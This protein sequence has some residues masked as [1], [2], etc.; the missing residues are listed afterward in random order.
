MQEDRNIQNVTLPAESHHLEAA[1]LERY[2]NSMMKDR[3]ED[4]D[5]DMRNI[6]WVACKDFTEEVGKQ[7]IEDYIETWEEMQPSWFHS[8]DFLCSTE[9]EHH[10]FYHYR[11]RFSTPTPRR[12]IQ[13]TASV[14]FGVDV[15][16]VK[17][18]SLPVV[19]V[20]ILEASRLIHTPG[21]TRFRK[22]W[23]EDIIESKS[24]LRRAVDF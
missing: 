20:F 14:Y 1:L 18:Q 19:V 24:L 17:P 4:S 10:R 11:A 2:R 16:K 12:P 8:L 13:G 23:L 21:Q 15:S 6:K 7:Q 3:V 9:E 5:P 22:K